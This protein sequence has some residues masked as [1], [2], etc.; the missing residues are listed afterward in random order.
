CFV[1]GAAASPCLTNATC[2]CTDPIFF[3]SMEP[4]VRS[5]CIIEDA[6]LVKNASKARCGIEPHDSGAMY[7]EIS[8]IMTSIAIFLVLVRISYRQW[9]IR[10]GLGPDDWTIIAVAASCIPCTV[11]NSR[12][13]IFGIGRDIWTLTPNDITQFGLHFWIITLLYFADM[14]LLKLSILFFFL[15]IF[16]ELQF[17]RKMWVTIVVVILYGVAF[18]LTALFQCWPISYNWTRWNDTANQ[19]HCVN[20]AAIA[21]ANAAVG[22]ALDIWMLYLPMSQISSLNASL[23]KKIAIGAMFVVG[24][25]V[26]VVSIV[27][28]ASLLQFRSSDNVTYDYTGV[29]LWSTVEI[30]T[31]VICACMPSMRLILI[32]FFPNIFGTTAQNSAGTPQNNR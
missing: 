13:A 6:L 18:V 29:S 26:T 24:T 32:H 7:T 20:N 17:R 4:C 14:A 16:P 31:G 11:I 25:F 1:K 15:R 5:S 27:R 23:K 22:I 2:L 12:L 9:V 30:S 19:G 21:W 3:A 8:T 28:L 10:L